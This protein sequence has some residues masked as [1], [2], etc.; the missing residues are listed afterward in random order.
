MTHD[1]AC[2]VDPCACEV[3]AVVVARERLI[4]QESWRVNLPKIERRNYKQGWHDAKA[5]P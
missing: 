4:Y 2:P 1:P 3:I 5:S